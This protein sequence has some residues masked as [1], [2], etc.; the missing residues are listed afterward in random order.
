VDA[1]AF[2]SIDLE[3]RD[4]PSIARRR[5][6]SERLSLLAKLVDAERRVDELRRWIGACDRMAAEGEH[7]ELRRMLAWAEL[8]LAELDS[9]R[10][11][12]QLSKMLRE[13]DLFPV[14]DL[15]GDPD[16]ELIDYR[17]RA[18]CWSLRHVNVV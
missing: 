16:G 17:A 12:E 8:R 7:P 15:L 6:E 13:R 3:K 11:T 18:G 2:E 9:S 4:C 5:R 14:F 1:D 10:D